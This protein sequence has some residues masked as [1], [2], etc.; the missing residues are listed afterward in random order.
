MHCSANVENSLAAFLIGARENSFYGCSTGW[1]VGLDPVDSACTFVRACVRACVRVR[2]CG[3][4][5]RRP[6]Q[7]RLRLRLRL[8]LWRARAR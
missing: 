3:A 4:L 1:D 8:R 2:A 5:Q 6:Q 7:L